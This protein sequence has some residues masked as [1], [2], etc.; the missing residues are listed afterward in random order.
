AG[1]RRIEA[2]TGRGVEEYVSRMQE[3]RLE[4]AKSIKAQPSELVDRVKRLSDHVSKLEKDLKKALTS[5][6]SAGA[7]DLMDKVQ[8]VGGIKVLTAAIDVPDR[9]ILG[10]LAEK[11][12]DKLKSGVVVLGS[13]LEEKVALIAAVSKDLTPKVHAGN[14]IK[15]IS[16]IVGGKG[17]GR[18]DFAQGGGVDASKLEEALSQVAD[19][20]KK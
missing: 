17:G 13:E 3:E 8:D 5:G 18:P 11:Y 15:A 9:K 10:E 20:V 19:F 12:R 2:V 4:I 14:I 7:A 6:A 1:V 16:E